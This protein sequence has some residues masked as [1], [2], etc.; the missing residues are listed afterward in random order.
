MI[1]FTSDIHFNH[2]N[3]IKYA[4]TFRKY[5]S[6]PE[7]NKGLIELWNNTVTPDDTVYNLG[8]VMF[9]SIMI[10]ENYDLLDRL[11]GKHYLIAGNHDETIKNPENKDILL[12][13]I[14]ADGN[15]L[16]EDIVDYLEIS[17]DN[18]FICMSH[19]PMLRWNKGQFGSYMLY[20]HMHQEMLPIPGRILNVGYDLHG[21]LLSIDEVN[22]FIGGL[23]VSKI[24]TKDVDDTTIEERKVYI[25]TYLKEIN[26]KRR[27][28]E[29]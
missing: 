24:N 20:G 9:G 1:Y 22:N 29:I 12:R 10:K 21:K 23:P 4:P 25:K 28:N 2:K 15:K 7:M 13:A 17:I 3:I 6:I 19:Y 18:K 26:Y 14:K 8:D 11:N 16:F 27:E 5:N